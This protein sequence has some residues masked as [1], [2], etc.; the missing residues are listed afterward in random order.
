LTCVKWPEAARQHP[1][2]AYTEALDFLAGAISDLAITAARGIQREV[3]ER[4]AAI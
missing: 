2:L 1:P 4:A 3:R